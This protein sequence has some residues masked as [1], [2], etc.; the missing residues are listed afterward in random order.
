MNG[1]ILYV[2]GMLIPVTYI[3]MYILGGVLRPDYSHISNSVSEL[4][5]PGAP[6]KSLLMVIQTIYALL[7]IAFGYG[8]L[9]F[10]QG[11]ANNQLIG[12]AGAWL[13][14]TLGLATIGTVFFPQDAEGTPVTVAGQIHKILVFG[15][16]IPFSVLSTLFIGLWFRRAGIL[17]GFDVYSFITVGAIVVMGG[18]GGA[19]VETQY[20]GLVERIAALVTQQWL[21]M[22]G[23]KLLL[24]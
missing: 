5:S 22:L 13:I 11:N 23:V 6:N 17:P 10:I 14:I 16:L 8:V 1:K 9:R 19:T 20:A 18:V 12:R 24:Q 15:G 3:F 21:F 4:L 2:F 7:H